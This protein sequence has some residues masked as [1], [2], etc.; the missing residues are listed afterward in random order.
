[1]SL[2]ARALPPSVLHEPHL[3]CDLGPDREIAPVKV[4]ILDPEL[5]DLA[6]RRAEK[7]IKETAIRS[8]IVSAALRTRGASCSTKTSGGLAE[9]GPGGR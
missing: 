5:L 7:S 4:E 8:S 3:H 9:R 2:P 1:M 6:T